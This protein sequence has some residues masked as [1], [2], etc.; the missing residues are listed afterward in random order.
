MIPPELLTIIATHSTRTTTLSPIMFD[1]PLPY[2][3]HSLT[4][5]P[6]YENIPIPNSETK[7]EAAADVCIPARR[8]APR[9][10]STN[11][12]SL[13]WSQK[14]VRKAFVSSTSIRP[15]HSAQSAPYAVSV[16][17][18]AA[19]LTSARTHSV[20]P[21]ARS[22]APGLPLAATAAAYSFPGVASDEKVGRDMTK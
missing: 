13:L 3:L 15:P 2:Q 12:V 17:S 16:S 8:K 6:S 11:F 7:F 5:M 14:V 20:A 22:G 19:A 10:G 18:A 4:S 1:I 21:A 9:P